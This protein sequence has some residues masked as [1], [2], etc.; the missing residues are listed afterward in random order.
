[1][2]PLKILGM[3]FHPRMLLRE[4]VPYENFNL[5]LALISRNAKRPIPF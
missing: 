3:G 4:L 2:F 1:M 5:N